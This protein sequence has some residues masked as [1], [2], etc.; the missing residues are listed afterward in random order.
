MMDKSKTEWG[1]Y[2]VRLQSKHRFVTRIVALYV[3]KLE[4]HLH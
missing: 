2:I 3:G 1:K 4:G